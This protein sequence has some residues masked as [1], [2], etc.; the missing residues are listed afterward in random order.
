MWRAQQ[1]VLPGGE[2]MLATNRRCGRRGP[3]PVLDTDLGGAAYGT[4]RWVRK[5]GVSME[6]LHVRRKD[7][8]EYQKSG[9]LPCGVL[10]LLQGSGMGCIQMDD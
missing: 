9:P 2:H 10:L 1:P 7:M 4:V 3:I 8:K 6:V 5:E